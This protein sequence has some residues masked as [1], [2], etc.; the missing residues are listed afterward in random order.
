MLI[1][2]S[3]EVEDGTVSVRRHGQGQQDTLSVDEF[4]ELI[5]NEIAEQI[6]D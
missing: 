6:G 3:R 1:V 5:A 4:I 2:G